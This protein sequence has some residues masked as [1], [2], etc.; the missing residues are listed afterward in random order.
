M[1]PFSSR[2]VLFTALF[3]ANAMIAAP[4]RA[5]DAAT[6]IVLAETAINAHDLDKALAESPRLQP[7]ISIFLFAPTFTSRRK[8]TFAPSPTSTMPSN[9]TPKVRIAPKRAFRF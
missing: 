9:L 2:C 1:N 8:I 7:A 4:L 5:D 3:F 6:H